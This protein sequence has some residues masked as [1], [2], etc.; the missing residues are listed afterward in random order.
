[1]QSSNRFMGTLAS[2]AAAFVSI[3]APASATVYTGLE[4]VQ[5]QDAPP[6]IFYQGGNA[7]NDSAADNLRVLCPLEQANIVNTVDPTVSVMDQN[8]TDNVSCFTRLCNFDATG[9]VNTQA[10]TS[11]FTGPASLVL[12]SRNTPPNGYAV[13]IC[14]LPALDIDRS[15]VLAYLD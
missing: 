4:C 15:G 8:S 13:I 2:L 12:N 7:F 10:A 3:A 5:A 6:S 14:D 9:C 11:T 1:M